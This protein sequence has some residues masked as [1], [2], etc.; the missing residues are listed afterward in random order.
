MKKKII[1]G[2]IFILVISLIVAIILLIRNKVVNDDNYIIKKGNKIFGTEYC[3]S[4]SFFYNDS[5]HHSIA[6][7]AITPYKC[8][9]CNKEYNYPNTAIP[10]ICPSCAEITGRCMA[11]GKLKRQ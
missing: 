3:P 1:I 7:Q 11:C 6:G 9:I 2:L 8:K 10:K 4:D 5:D